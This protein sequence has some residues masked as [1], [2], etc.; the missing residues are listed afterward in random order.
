MHI[1]NLCSPACTLVVITGGEPLRQNITPLVNQ[2]LDRNL[3]V[4]IETNGTLTLDL[5]ENPN[6]IIICSPKTP[7]LH[8][9]IIPR[10]HAYKY[11]IAAEE[12]DTETGLPNHSTQ[13]FGQRQRLFYPP[14]GRPV[15]IM[16]RDDRNAAFHR[17]ACLKIALKYGYR[18]CLQIQ[19][20]LDIK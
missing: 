16:P 10:I 14:P 19:K 1:D 15:F 6:L 9:E 5:P 12:T 18:V 4:Q 17:R 8:P 7:R 20:L 2:L 3:R 13:E 11:V